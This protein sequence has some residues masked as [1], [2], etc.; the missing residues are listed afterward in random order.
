MEDLCSL[1]DQNHK[2]NYVITT[3]I[4]CI[5]YIIDCEKEYLKKY[6]K[7]FLD[8]FLFVH[9]Y[10]DKNFTADLK[11][12]IGS[13]EEVIVGFKNNETLN[14]KI[15]II[16]SKHG[17]YKLTEEKYLEV[18]NSMNIKKFADFNTGKILIDGK[19]LVEPTDLSEYIKTEEKLYGTSLIN[20]LTKKAMI[21]S[22]E[23][24]KLKKTHLNDT[25]FEYEKYLLS[26]DEINAYTFISNHNYK[27]LYEYYSS[28]Q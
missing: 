17:N 3:N 27:T 21:L 14:K 12:F 24:N 25:N 2:D 19:E 20:E 18:I 22:I 23:D 28:Q 11:N 13:N 16:H 26:I 6:R 1:K 4:G 15:R 7:V 8:D 5:P 9:S 10:Y